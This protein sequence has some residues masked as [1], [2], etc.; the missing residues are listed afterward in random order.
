MFIGVKLRSNEKVKGFLKATNERLSKSLSF[1]GGV[2]FLEDPSKDF[3]KAV[4]ILSPV[5]PSL[6]L[7]AFYIF[8]VGFGWW[9]IFGVVIN[10]IFILSAFFL[11]TEY[12]RTPDFSF[13]IL[14]LGLKKVGYK[15]S[16][17]LFNDYEIMEVLTNGTK[18][19]I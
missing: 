9:Y 17:E 8:L 6:K 5:I 15:G 2:R 1:K 18:G 19:N 10:A 7:L 14:K 13:R 12:F 16:Y 3:L 4:F 11:G